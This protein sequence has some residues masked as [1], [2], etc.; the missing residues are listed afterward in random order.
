MILFRPFEAR[1]LF[2][3]VPPAWARISRR[4]AGCVALPWLQARDVESAEHARKGRLHLGVDFPGG[5]VDRGEDK[6]LQHFDVAG[7]YGFRID[8][9]AEELLA[10]IHFSGYGSAA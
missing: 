2:T 3:S 6:V 4:F 9:Q 8:A 5:L 10:A 1:P 7:F